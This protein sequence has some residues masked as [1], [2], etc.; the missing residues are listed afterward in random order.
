MKRCSKILLAAVAT[1]L[2]LVVATWSFAS[3]SLRSHY[4]RR[5]QADNNKP[6]RAGFATVEWNVDIKRVIC[7]APFLFTAES[8]YFHRTIEGFGQRGW[9]VW[10]P[11]RVYTLH[12][13][14]IWIS[15]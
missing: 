14:D 7:P 6:G 5:I 15:Q 10:T 2:L 8:Y 9:Y 1:Y 12:L 4:L 13:T 3:E 11:W